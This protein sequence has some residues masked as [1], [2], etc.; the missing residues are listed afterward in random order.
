[1]TKKKIL[2]IAVGILVINLI[3]CL[4]LII[5][6]FNT[7]SKL[8]VPHQEVKSEI[9]FIPSGDTDKEA[10]PAQETVTETPAE[11]QKVASIL[12]GKSDAEIDAELK[13]SETS[14]L[15]MASIVD[16]V[17]NEDVLKCQEFVRNTKSTD[18]DKYMMKREC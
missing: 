1:M 14:S 5:S 13:S 6:N 4:W 15:K 7:D 3:F 10:A 2:P 9:P 8:E 11:T 12:E 18:K 16:V 17:K